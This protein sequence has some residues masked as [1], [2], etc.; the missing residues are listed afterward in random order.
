MFSR[1]FEVLEYFWNPHFTSDIYWEESV[2]VERKVVVME[3]AIWMISLFWFKA[4]WKIRS[5]CNSSKI[6]TGPI[7]LEDH[8]WIH[9]FLSN[10]CFLIY[11]YNNTLD[12]FLHEINFS[13]AIACSLYNVILIG[14]PYLLLCSYLFWVGLFFI[15]W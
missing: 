11:S 8:V 2:F 9:V 15:F 7:C 1:I 5:C 12:C 10:M 13:H 4:G 14:K 6:A 3:R